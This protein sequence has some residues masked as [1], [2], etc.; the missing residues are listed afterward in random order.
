MVKRK[1]DNGKIYMDTNTQNKIFETMLQAGSLYCELFKTVFNSG[2]ENYY[3]SWEEMYRKLSDN[4]L[5]FYKEVTE[6]LLKGPQLGIYREVLHQLMDATE[7]HHQFVT[8][9]NDFL[10]KFN[11]PMKKSFI[12][13]DRVLKSKKA[14][15]NGLKN[16]KK[17]YDLIT[18]IL[19][20]EYDDYLKSPE[21]IQDVADVIQ[22]YV[23]YR[24]KTDDAKDIWLKAFSIPTTKEMDDVYKN[25][26]QLKKQVREQDK[27][28]A[29]QQICI[30]QLVAEI[31]SIE[32]GLK[33]PSGKSYT[34][35]VPTSNKKPAR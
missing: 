6:R 11:R 24:E 2:K 29:D 34:A 10:V 4:T 12:K 13:L 8:E 30:N 35:Q 17:F 14:S 19:E 5:W 32:T 31:K 28:I 25:L 15:E 21:G 23:T 18:G 22:S 3:E 27:L 33:V 20:K 7:G 26:Y 16:P 9:L 1:M